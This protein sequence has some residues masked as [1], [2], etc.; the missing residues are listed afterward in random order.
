MPAIMSK[1]DLATLRKLEDLFIQ[2]P[3]RQQD[4]LMGFLKGMVE[5]AKI[6]DEGA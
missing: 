6:K 3:P 4:F 2:I 5:A 1:A